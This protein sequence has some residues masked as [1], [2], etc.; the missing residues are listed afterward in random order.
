MGE[1]TAVGNRIHSRQAE[2]KRGSA[3]KRDKAGPERNA[4]CS[5]E[6][7]TARAPGKVYRPMMTERSH[8]PR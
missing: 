1:P 7:W 5:T 3:P 6:R 2:S 4:E 8:S